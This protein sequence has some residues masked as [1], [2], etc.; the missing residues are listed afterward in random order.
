MAEAAERYLKERVAIH[1]KATSARI[2][3]RPLDKFILPAH[4]HIKAVRT[5]VQSNVTF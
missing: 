3:R 1:C 4:G 5:F 2:C